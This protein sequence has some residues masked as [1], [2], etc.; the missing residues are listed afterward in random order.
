MFTLPLMTKAPALDKIKRTVRNR[1]EARRVP[2]LGREYVVM[3]P[4]HFER[5]I[6][7]VR[8]SSDS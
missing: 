2:T 6:K 5:D 7:H 4:G 3:Y 8:Y 1:L